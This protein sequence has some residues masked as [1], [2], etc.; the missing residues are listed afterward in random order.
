[1]KPNIPLISLPLNTFFLFQT[2]SFFNL[3]KISIC[4]TF[5]LFQTYSFFNI[6]EISICTNYFALA[7]LALTSSIH[8]AARLVARPPLLCVSGSEHRTLASSCTSCQ[9]HHLPCLQPLTS[10]SCVC[11]TSLVP[12]SFVHI[13]CC[14]CTRRSPRRMYKRS[15]PGTLTVREPG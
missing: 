2:Y 8:A 1:V 4:T 7:M 13:V 9:E 3:I 5:F 15:P 14:Y 10:T 6:T 12:T 11:V